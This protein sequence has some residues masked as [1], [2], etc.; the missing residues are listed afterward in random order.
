MVGAV[1]LEQLAD[2]RGRDVYDFDG[3]RI[4]AIEE[5]FYESATQRAEWIGIGTSFFPDRRL[6][7]PVR[8]AELRDD[9][10]SLPYDCTEVEDAPD[11][12]GDV[13]APVVEHA[14]IA[15]YGL[16]YDG[17]AG[18]LP[19]PGEPPRLRKLV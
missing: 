1:T 13:I 12:D 8:G 9:G 6:L 14:L 16:D 3:R 2:S 19:A 11:V 18:E 15:H 7:V 4:G 5:I 17:D 10:I